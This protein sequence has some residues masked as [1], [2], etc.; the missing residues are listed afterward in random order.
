[1]RTTFLAAALTAAAGSTAMAQT[2]RWT[3]RV[4]D[5]SLLQNCEVALAVNH[6]NGDVSVAWMHTLIGGS[7]AVVHVHYNVAAD[8]TTFR[9]DPGELPLPSG[10]DHRLGDPMAAYGADGNGWVGALAGFTTD[11][12]WVA[13]KAA[14][15]PY[16]DS[17][18]QEAD[19]F[20]QGVDKGI[21]VAGPAL[22]GGSDTVSVIFARTYFEG[23]GDVK[24]IWEES[25]PDGG[26]TWPLANE[27]PVGP[28]TTPNPGNLGGPGSAVILRNGSTVGR[29]V[30]A[31]NKDGDIGATYSDPGSSW[32]N[33]VLPLTARVPHSN[34]AA[35]ETVTPLAGDFLN[36]HDHPDGGPPT[37]NFPSIAVDPTNGNIV[38]MVFAGTAPSSGGHNAELFLAR[39]TDGGANFSYSGSNPAGS[40]VLHLSDGDL[41]EN[42]GTQ[43]FLPTVA[44]D[45]NGNVSIVYYVARYLTPTDTPINEYQVKYVRVLPFDV[46]PQ[47]PSVSNL[48]TLA[49]AFQLPSNT[50]GFPT[51]SGIFFG[52][53]IMADTRVCDVYAGFVS[54][55]SYSS[56]VLGTYVSKVSTCSCYAN[57]DNSTV[58]PVLNINDFVCFLNAFAAGDPYANC[59]GSSVSPVLNIN[60]FVCFQNAIAAGCP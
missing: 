48:S 43:E 46:A 20:G 16:V 26:A 44:V 41:G 7:N 37:T 15:N 55:T 50:S 21:L 57:C 10:A 11:R 9:S 39:S 51:I 52:D 53:Y 58:T 2:Y 18:I 14:G 22:S 27:A 60:D 23:G 28:A 45:H 36:N 6:L 29:W 42:D 49:P 25:S 34:P 17:P 38:Y 32:V 1:M 31:T 35:Y 19:F 24:R 30:V 8:G 47:N 3:T 59:D 56:G 5:G 40:Q 54:R 13:H 33:S 4:D 12:F